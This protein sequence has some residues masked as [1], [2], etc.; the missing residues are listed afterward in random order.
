MLFI[1]KINNTLNIIH[2]A[3]TVTNNI[4]KIKLNQ[5]RHS[6][7]TRIF[8]TIVRVFNMHSNEKTDSP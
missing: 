4:E 6:V 7:Y 5:V 2:L 3:F 8:C 1:H